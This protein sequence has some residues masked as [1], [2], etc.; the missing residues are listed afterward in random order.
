MECYKAQESSLE[1]IKPSKMNRLQRSMIKDRVSSVAK[2]STVNMC[3]FL[4]TTLEKVV[5]YLQAT[6]GP[7]APWKSEKESIAK[8]LRFWW[9][10]YKLGTA[11]VFDESTFQAH[12]AIG[13]EIFDHQIRGLQTGLQSS[14]LLTN[15]LEQSRDNFDSGFKLNT[16]LGMEK[17]W[18]HFRP[19]VASSTTTHDTLQ[20]MEQLAIRFDKLRWRTSILPTELGHIMHGL[21][22]AYRLLL[23]SG[24]DGQTLIE[25]LSGEMTTL[26]ASIGEE[27]DAIVPYLIDEFEHLRQYQDL[28]KTPGIRNDT[29]DNALVLSNFPTVSH[30][31]QATTSTTATN[32]QRV[33]Y[34]QGE[35]G[36]VSPLTDTLSSSTLR[37]LRQIGNVDLKSL[38]MLESELQVFGQKVASSSTL[39]LMDQLGASD[40]LLKD[41]CTSLF[42]IYDTTSDKVEK[43]SLSINDYEPY[44]QPVHIDHMKPIA[45][46]LSKDK[47]T[48]ADQSARLQDSALAWAHCAIALV[49]LYVPDRAFDPDKRQRLELEQ[50]QDVVRALNEKLSALKQFELTFTGQDSNLRCWLL[51]QEIAELGPPP[52]V[53]QI[54]YRPANSELNQ[55]HGEFKNLV[56]IVLGTTVLAILESYFQ[57]EDEAK[58]Q[59][60][61]LL[62]NNVNQIIRRLTERFHGYR[63]LTV[64]AVSML[65][66]LLLALSM[67]TLST[68]PVSNK[69]QTIQSI[70]AV[71]PF[72]GGTPVFTDYSFPESNPM[73]Y[74]SLMA[75]T[76][77]VVNLTKF[78]PE[79]REG[80]LRTFHICYDQW[81]RRL[82]ADRAEAESKSGLYRFR[83]SAE[84]EEEDDQEEFNE[85]FP[86][87]DDEVDEDAKNINGVATNSARETAVRL[88]EIHAEIV[89]GG[90]D[91]T[92]S[93]EDFIQQMSTQIGKLHDKD[94]SGDG[95]TSAKVLPGVMLSLNKQILALESSQQSE[96]YNFYTD[97][98]LPESRK[99]V[100]LIHSV[101]ARFRQLQAVDEIAHMQPLADVLTACRELLAFN[102][103]EPLAKIITKV[104]KVHTFAHEWQ[105]GG[106]ASRATSALT[107]YDGLTKT[108]V[109]W[110][111]IE[112]STWGRLFEMETKKCEDDAKSWW[113]VAYQVVIAAPLQM[114][115]SVKQLQEYASN[116]VRDLESYF[117]TAIQGQFTQ[118]LRLLKQ[119]QQHLALAAKDYP[120]LNII[121]SALTNFILM[122]A[123]FEKP[124]QE[125]LKRG[126]ASLEKAMRDVLL[127]ASWKDTN[128]VALRDSAKRSHHKLFKIV[129]KFR[130]LLSQPMDIVIRQGIPDE[131]GH[132]A[133]E[134]KSSS[135][136]H[137]PS[138]DLAALTQ[139]AQ[140]VPTWSKKSKRFINV[141][142]TVGV[143]VEATQLPSD[144]VDAPVYLDSF[145]GNIVTSAAELQ[146]AT[147]SILDEGTKDVVKHLK[148]RK[149]KLFA[150]TLKE[151]KQM[152]IKYNLGVNALAKQESLS[153]VLANTGCVERSSVSGLQYYFYKAMDLTTKAR[154]AVKGHNEDLSGR[155]VERSTGFLEGLLQVIITQR[156]D[157]SISM[158]LSR[159]LQSKVAMAT[160]MWNSGKSTVIGNLTS[161]NDFTNVLGW[162][163]NVMIVAGKLVSIHAKFC[164]VDLK[165]VE[166]RLAQWSLELKTLAKTIENL[167]VLPFQVLSIQHAGIASEVQ[168]KVQTLSTELESLSRERPELKYIIN[169]IVPWMVM[170]DK[171]VQRYN[172][173][174]SLVKLDQKVS[175]LCDSILV[176][177]EKYKSAISKLPVSTD[178]EDWLVS[179]NKAV[180]QSIKT[181]HVKLISTEIDQAFGILRTVDLSD[182]TTSR[183]A[184]A[185]FAVA[186]PI[187]E[188]YSLI[189]HDAENQYA[190]LHRTT[191]K[192]HYILAKTFIQIAT[193]GFCTPSEKADAQDGKTEKLEG[194]TGLGDGE[195]AE[196]ISK[197]I[198]DDENL[199]ELAQE[200]N[201]G[202][203]D[204]IEDEKD[205]VDMADSEMEGKMGEAEEKGEDEDGSGDESEGENEMDEET[206]DVDDL[207]P[208]AVDE[209]MWDGDGEEAE[210]D[211][212]GDDSK[213]K[214]K[215]DEQVAG[216]DSDKKNEMG[217]EGEGDE[218]E[219]DLEGAEQGEEVKQQDDVEKHDPHAEEGEALDLPDD[220]ELDGDEDQKSVE[221]SDDGIDDLPDVA[222]A[223]QEEETM[224]DGKEEEGADNADQHEDQNPADD[225]DVID[226]DEDQEGDG[227]K[228]EEAGEKDGQEDL[229]Q[230]LHEEDYGLLRDRD[231]E[232]NADQD[233][234]V[235]SDVQGVGED[236]NETSKDE[237]TDSAS[238][239][240]C[241]EGGEGG[242]SSEQKS[243]AA[244]DGEQGRQAN[245]AA[246]QDSKEDT[247]DTMD[248]QPFKKLGDTLESWHRQQTQ[249]RD[250]VEQKEEDQNP[251]LS[252]DAQ[253]FQ[254]LQDENAEADNQAMGT[255]TEDQA[256]AL[257]E[258][259]AV[260]SESKEMPDQFQPDEVE[261]ETN[262]QDDD[263][264]D[265]EESLEPAPQDTSDAYE[266]RAGAM[267]KQAEE[268]R[269]DSA[270]QSHAR[271][272]EDVEED[273]EEVDQRLDH[274]HLDDTTI[275]L[276]SAA[277]ARQ[278]W[279]H[280]EG[281]TRDL[282][283]AL[284]EQLRLILA[285]TLATKMRGDFRTGKRLNIKRIIPYIASQYKR[286]KIWMRRSVPSKRSYQIMLAVDDSKSMGESGSGSLAFE[287]LVMVSKSLSMLE[288]GEI[289][290]VGFGETV[291]VAHEFEQPFSS[292]AGPKV[293]QNFS[294]DQPRTDVTRL[295]RES[296]ELFRTA[297]AKAS[298]TPADLWQLQLIISDGVCDSSEH[299]PIRRLLRE[300]LEERIMMV[301]VVVDDLKNKKKGESV[302]DLKEAKF[303]KNEMTGQ[304]Q[305]KIERYLD[306]FPF[307]YY[308]IVSDVRELPGVLAAVLRQWF[309]E[310]VDSGN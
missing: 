238:K 225:M 280:Y 186:Q 310:V 162:L 298:S 36:L 117:A 278:Q 303:V 8:I 242:E 306:T 115:D 48:F 275:S 108:I 41:L 96:Y 43:G 140:H 9:Q 59:E 172:K 219:E 37:K 4:T 272:Q 168:Q 91:S 16:G 24:I 179:S 17:M 243:A 125:H 297:R 216:Q 165:D 109:N 263:V 277:D 60:I 240:Q 188:Q 30:M 19:L 295:V 293:F 147:P 27:E 235:P 178:E 163:P 35:L 184:A 195:G 256:R 26:E 38:R 166:G 22:K 94:D 6:T 254:H 33:D 274:T 61:K 307:Q 101:Q 234:A 10:T 222:D 261:E 136:I 148:T 102:H 145:L 215:K 116:L 226:L 75:T 290:V 77:N 146:K 69:A 208:T 74:L 249:I 300:A 90:T 205:A 29:T 53:L 269:D 167:Q 92:K 132:E 47:T 181:L 268:K 84:D 28:S 51:E 301:F 134:S 67:A 214:Q 302:M 245:G 198:Q 230:Q 201:S 173:T 141:S 251:D 255:A 305:V 34:V 207:D 229:E 57:N 182:V 279:T 180:S 221:G 151:L 191:C 283:L 70:S 200:P 187:L 130:A 107:E 44:F 105:F 284:T 183:T 247:K 276:R 203:K 281:I 128:I 71:T 244:E 32:L 126:R 171:T 289:C 52:A 211:Q 46:Y 21:V 123:R 95:E 110:R 213:G 55:L 299:E 250:P 31:R 153:L 246:P 189:V 129:R 68:K 66:C 2:D 296:I 50:H 177:V 170:P 85:L 239:T 176:A 308:L 40:G 259:M 304:S 154:D 127:L 185:I 224:N 142:K 220:M 58:L 65:R 1:L 267:I 45:S 206:G 309:A 257:D 23:T 83:G 232:A 212:E 175:K 113:F 63:D 87:F 88:A 133:T 156:N 15:I 193:Q 204:E 135:P 56:K 76:S 264:M 62:Q 80:V 265:L 111:R 64:P 104:E 288:V 103:T 120:N 270:D 190:L 196:D 49:T 152:G 89:L 20:Q 138:V 236:Q 192:A 155:E 86:T 100:V 93:L 241:E 81:T 157:L 218:E 273:V 5:S 12:L 199:D 253:E 137:F 97:A 54:I 169:Q 149:R 124:V 121:Y 294:F 131:S 248:A 292:D 237:K 11:S 266:G 14:D 285:P 42:D 18:K 98:N 13:T 194:G 79:Q 118:R 271:R 287:T 291:K 164:N 119:L 72:L 227:D 78:S 197:D 3:T 158:T 174:G 106:W 209:K 99:L 143:M 73:E 262:K 210:K 260:D 231:D 160:E 223:Q 258:S 112:L 159:E 252:Q 286:D 7:I 217:E 144:A 82:E 282:S 114:S 233:N 161:D 228:T 202:D 139:C 39:I 25:A 150:D 122:F